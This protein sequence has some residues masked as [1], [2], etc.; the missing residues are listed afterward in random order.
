MTPAV[1]N[2]DFI[3]RILIDARHTPHVVQV[4]AIGRNT[5]VNQY[6]ITNN[7]DRNQRLG[8]HAPVVGE[9]VIECYQAALVILRAE[10]EHT[11]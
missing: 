11:R 3:V 6:F 7:S 8:L 10:R 2:A 1:E 9:L 4:V 5:I